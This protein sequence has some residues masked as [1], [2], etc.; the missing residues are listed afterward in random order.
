[1]NLQLSRERATAVKDWLV[2][3]GGVMAAN[4][5]AAGR[6]EENPVAPNKNP[7][8]ITPPAAPRIAA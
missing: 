3:N 1:V 6:G 2:K 7:A 4:I 5:T 8:A